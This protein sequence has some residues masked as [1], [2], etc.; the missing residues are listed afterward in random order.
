MNDTFLFNLG[1]S[2]TK[3]Y[4]AVESSDFIIIPL[5]PNNRYDD[6]FKNSKVT[7]S[8][9]LMLGFLKPVIINQEFAFSY[10]LNKKNTIFKTSYKSELILTKKYY[11]ISLIK[12][13]S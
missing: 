9:Q 13:F 3:L 5:D 8:L 11:L 10:N 7:G 4:K 6:I 1:V 12:F 2:Y